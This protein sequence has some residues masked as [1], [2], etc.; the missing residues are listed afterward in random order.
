MD[1]SNQDIKMRAFKVII[2]GPQAVGKSSILFR[3]SESKFNTAYLSTVGIDFKTYTTQVA[4]KLYSL[5]IWDTAGQ[6]KFRALTSSYYKGSQGCICVFDLSEIGTLERCDYYIN[7]A[8]EE[9]VPKECIFLV[10]NKTDIP[11]DGSEAARDLAQKYEINYD[12]CSAKE[13]TKVV[14]IFDGLGAKLVKQFGGGGQEEGEEL[15][16]TVKVH[17]GKRNCCG[18]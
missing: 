15:K 9:N 7:K 2:V 17:E 14:E 13:G 5:Q 12:E 1:N 6:E 3:L 11:H 8:L 10:G 18:R 16:P 4:D